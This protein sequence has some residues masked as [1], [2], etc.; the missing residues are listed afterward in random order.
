VSDAGA[1]EAAFARARA[2]DLPGALASLR[3]RVRMAPDD[4]DAWLTLGMLLAE[5]DDAAEAVRALTR[6]VALDAGA[7]LGRVLLARALERDGRLDD[8]ETALVIARALAPA[9]PGIARELGCLAYARGRHDEALAHLATAASLAPP[10]DEAA[11]LAFARGLVH[12][13]RRDLGA[14]IAAYR[15]AVHADPAHATAWRTLADA[16]AQVGEHAGAIEAL[17]ALLALR[18]RDE[19]ALHNRSVLGA[20]LAAMHARRLLGAAPLALDASA[21]VEGGAMHRAAAP[22]GELRYEGT[23]ASLHATL[24][25]EGRVASLFFAVDADAPDA[26]AARFGV[27]VVGDAGAQGDTSYATAA[28][29]TFLRE[30]IGVPMTEAARLLARMLTAAAP[31]REGDAEAIF[32]S[33]G[34]RHGIRVSLAA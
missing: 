14:A 5:T 20:A 7:V 29:L 21:V 1:S 16:L 13:A 28:T 9:H 33:V 25:G 27:T 11:R 22:D 30:G 3:E 4:S 10:P 2:G 17:D 12:E 23:F 18:P 32:T 26:D 31:I 19:G 8:A 6:A 24:D 34:P 15:D